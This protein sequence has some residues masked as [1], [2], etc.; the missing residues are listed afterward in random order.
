MKSSSPNPALRALPSSLHESAN[1]DFLR[2][3]AVL[4]VFI[5]HLYGIYTGKGAK[6]DFFWHIGQ[7][8]VLMFFVHS[9]LVLMW[10]LERS[11]LDGWRVF[12]PF[13]VRRAFRLYPLSVVCVLIAYCFDARWSPV[14]L[15]PNLTLTQNL[16]FTDKPVIPPTLTPLWSLPLEVQMYIVLPVLF[17]ILRNRSLK[18]LALL[19]SSSIPVALLQ[20][21]WGER[22][23]IFKYAPCF[24]GGVVAWR[25]MRDTARLPGWLW[26]L[27]IVA[28]S[29]TWMTAAPSYLPLHIAAC[30]ICLGLAIPLFREIPWSHVRT[31]SRI[32]ARYSYS[33]YLSHFPIM[34]YVFSDPRDPRFKLIRQL[35]PMK[36]LS[37]TAH[38][39]LFLLLSV[40]APPA[41][42][43]L[44]E[45]PGI[46]L[47]HKLARWISGSEERK[48]AIETVTAENQSP[49]A[50]TL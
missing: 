8:G 49:D 11:G 3:V 29:L 18:L 2:A 50:A 19:W 16:F 23:E 12:V 40:L 28:A 26:P 1:L 4:L 22:F 13:Y 35:P 17:L 47:G 25:L 46:R 21:G 14:N 9:C 6:W 27:A 30:G 39:A 37:R 45:K 36:H 38:F 20:P 5:T 48:L 41:L 7:L 34:V 10:S 24:L 32:T 43:H 31:A 15:W 44:V 42:Y 33:I